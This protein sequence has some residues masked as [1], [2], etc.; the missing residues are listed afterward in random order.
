MVWLVRTIRRIQIDVA[1]APCLVHY[2]RVTGVLKCARRIGA[3]KKL[4]MHAAA[5]SSDPGSSVHIRKRLSA[6]S[7]RPQLQR[8]AA[9]SFPQELRLAAQPDSQ[10]AFKTQMAAGYDQHTLPLPDSLAELRARNRSLISQ[11]TKRAGLWRTERKEAAE[12]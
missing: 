2:Y 11:E 5:D 9:Q 7:Q 1:R 3:Q 8:N 4:E 12:T 6:S 10:E